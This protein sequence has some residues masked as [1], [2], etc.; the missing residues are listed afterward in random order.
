MTDHAL[1]YWCLHQAIVHLREYRVTKLRR[2]L[3]EARYYLNDARALAPGNRS[4]ERI[5]RIYMMIR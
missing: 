5:S 3:A 2:M 4:V 1:L